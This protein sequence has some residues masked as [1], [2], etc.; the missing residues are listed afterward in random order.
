MYIL[1]ILFSS[2]NKYSINKKCSFV[3]TLKSELNPST[4]ILISLF[5][6]L[7]SKG[8]NVIHVL[9]S[10]TYW[11][12]FIY[13]NENDKV[14]SPFTSCDRLILFWFVLFHSWQLYRYS[15]SRGPAISSVENIV[16]Y[17]N[18]FEFYF[19]EPLLVDTNIEWLVRW[20]AGQV[21]RLVYS[22]T[23]EGI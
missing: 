11:R 15:I 7:K 4:S 12:Y 13:I 5:D 10:N 6:G 1:I 19:I 18:G 21:L 8:E 2:Y 20:E 3:L 22:M 16:V 14:I 9:A 17:G 23:I